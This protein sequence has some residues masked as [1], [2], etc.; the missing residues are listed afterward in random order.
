VNGK[1][2]VISNENVWKFA[3]LADGRVIAGT[4]IGPDINVD[5]R[6]K[7]FKPTGEV[8]TLY[9]NTDPS[10]I[11]KFPDNNI[12]M[13]V[14][15]C[16]SDRQHPYGV[17]RYLSSTS[18]L[19]SQYWISNNVGNVNRPAFY[20][21]TDAKNTPNYVEVLE[22]V[23]GTVIK[24]LTTTASQKVFVVTGN[25]PQLVQYFPNVKKTTT[26]V[27]RVTIIEG[28]DNKIVVSGINSSGQ[29]ITVLYDTDTDTERVLIPSSDE[30]EMYRLNYIPSR[31]T[32]MFD[33]LR[34]SDNTYVIGS[35]DLATGQITAKPTG[36]GKLVNFLTF[37]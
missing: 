12:Y 5:R 23:S 7:L 18:S 35:V 30:Y 3:V 15:P 6:T 21:V 16:C 13:G 28:T 32:L 17:T 4:R 8:E 22:E 31:N 1:T 9:T 36:S 37:Q 34:F 19:D 11:S 27:D 24:A 26:Q 10:F 14:T 29:N 2:T 25:K 33:A 20:N